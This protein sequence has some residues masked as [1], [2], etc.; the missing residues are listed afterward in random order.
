MARFP[1]TGA[2]LAAHPALF[3]DLCALFEARAEAQ[4]PPS[5]AAVAEAERAVR[6]G[7]QDVAES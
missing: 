2:L 5:A 3:A 6:T 7:A 4:A 1:D